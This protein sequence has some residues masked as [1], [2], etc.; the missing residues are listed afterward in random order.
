MKKAG[1]SGRHAATL[2][3]QIPYI[4]QDMVLAIVF[5]NIV[6]MVLQRDDC[7]YTDIEAPIKFIVLKIR[8]K[9]GRYR[10]ISATGYMEWVLGDLRPSSMHIITEMDTRSGA[11]LARNAYNTE[12]GNRVASLMLMI[13]NKFYTTDRAEFIG[14]NGT[15]AAILRL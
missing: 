5:L 3:R 12:F 1:G 13:T 8:N 6:K 10:R 15:L 4:S 7:I 2:H 14:R 9:S 11:I